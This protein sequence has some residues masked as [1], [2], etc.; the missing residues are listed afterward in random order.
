M[1]ARGELQAPA[2]GEICR[3]PLAEHRGKAA[4][5]ERFLEGPQH[6]LRAPRANHH[7]AVGIDAEDGQPGGVEIAAPQT[8]QRA[9]A[10]AAQAADQGGGKTARRRA[11]VPGPAHALV[12][13][14]HMQRAARQTA[15]RQRP[16]DRID[17]ERDRRDRRDGRVVADLKS[18]DLGS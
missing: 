6:V 13:R 8:P 16:V 10:G 2:G 9:A 15:P 18:A 17:A 1:A 12:R 7:Q 14:H 11:P 4:R 3:R 5:G